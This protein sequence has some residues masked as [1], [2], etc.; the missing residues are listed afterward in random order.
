MKIPIF[1][2]NYI[3]KEKMINELKLPLLK[4]IVSFFPKIL[5]FK[6]IKHSLSAQNTLGLSQQEFR[7]FLALQQLIK[8]K[9]SGLFFTKIFE[10]FKIYRSE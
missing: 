2:N 1:F 5:F 7:I 6:T 10:L 3:F 9:K 8:R 4:I